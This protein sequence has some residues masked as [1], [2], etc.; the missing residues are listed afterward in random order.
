MSITS[1]SPNSFTEN[2]RDHPSRCR[3]YRVLMGGRVN[4]RL[5]H[6][7]WLALGQCSITVRR[8][9]RHFVIERNI[10][11][12]SHSLS[13]LQDILDTGSPMVTVI[14][15]LCLTFNISKTIWPFVGSFRHCGECSV[16][17]P[18]RMNIS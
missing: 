1:L 4:S 6:L 13:N 17:L 11:K 16:Y 15:A 9:T 18:T 10:S 5:L 2:V 12:S 3:R 8:R 14:S 7:F